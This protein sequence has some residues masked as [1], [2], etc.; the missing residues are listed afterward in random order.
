VRRADLL[1]P[2]T[3]T[4]EVDAELAVRRER[5]V[6]TSRWNS[7]CPCRRGAAGEQA[8]AR[9]V[10]SNGGDSPQLDRI[11]GLHVVVAVHERVGRRPRRPLGVHRG[12]AAVV[13]LPDLDGAETAAAATLPAIHSALRRTSRAWSGSPRSTDAQPRVEV[14]V[15]RA[16]V[17]GD[18]SRNGV[19]HGAHSRST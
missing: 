9:T 18:V 17:G 19:G 6:Q 1:S 4:L 5:R 12:V 13:G 16:G 11:D 2:S 8:V 3:I 14:V 10:G 15:E 7:T